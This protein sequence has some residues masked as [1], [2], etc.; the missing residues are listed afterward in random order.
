VCAVAAPDAVAPID[1]CGHSLNETLSKLGAVLEAND[2][3][4]N[5]PPAMHIIA[6]A[7]AAIRTDPKRRFKAGDWHDL[8]HASMALPYCS[9]FFT[10]RSLAHLLKHPP[11]SKRVEHQCRILCDGDEIIDYLEQLSR[12]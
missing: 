10:E 7:H 11:F 2:Y 5:C 9:A 12:A 6:A 1:Y 3:R 4:S 8:N